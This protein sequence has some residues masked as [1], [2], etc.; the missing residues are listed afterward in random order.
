MNRVC[1]RFRCI[2]AWSGWHKRIQCTSIRPDRSEEFFPRLHSRFLSDSKGKEWHLPSAW[3]QREFYY[4]AAALL[5]PFLQE[6]HTSYCFQVQTPRAGWQEETAMENNLS[7]ESDP[8]RSPSKTT[9][10]TRL[11][12]SLFSVEER[13]QSSEP[14]LLDVEGR[15]LA[16][17][18]IMHWE[19]KVFP[20]LREIG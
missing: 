9:F 18:E 1:T 2:P 7:P 13:K 19:K 6:P 4:L 5:P 12:W 17:F 14:W 8:F 10:S 20:K 15:L 16:L 11:P 3:V